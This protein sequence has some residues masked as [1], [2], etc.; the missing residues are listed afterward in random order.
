MNDNRETWSRPITLQPIGVVRGGR[1]SS[2]DD[3]WGGFVSTIELDAERFGPEAL[4]ALDSFSHVLVVF[5]FHLVEAGSEETG[6]RHPRGQKN[7]PLA[8]IFAQRAK[9]RPNRLGI[10]TC[11]VLSVEGTRLT[12]EG[13][14]AME[15]TPVIDLKPHLTEFDPRGE[16]HQPAWSH[17]VMA[18]YFSDTGEA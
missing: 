10:T 18:E 8:G 12:V 17:E 4:A 9:R 7:W 15:G 1:E 11:R 5:H 13:L 16:V 14:D 6:A 2:E 3:R